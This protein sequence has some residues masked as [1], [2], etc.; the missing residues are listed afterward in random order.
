VPEE[1]R[2]FPLGR[3]NVTDAF[4]PDPDPNK[5]YFSTMEFWSNEILLILTNFEHV[6]S[7]WKIDLRHCKIEKKI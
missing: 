7:L 6:I 5:Y 4:Y 3:V 2:F 1:D